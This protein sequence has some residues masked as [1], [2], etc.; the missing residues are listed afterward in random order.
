L[1]HVKSVGSS[2]I[3]F[4]QLMEQTVTVMIGHFL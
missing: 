3:E 4:N 2:G 1:R